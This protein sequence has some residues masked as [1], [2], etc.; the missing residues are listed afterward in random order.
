MTRFTPDQLRAILEFLEIGT[1]LNHEMAAAMKEQQD[2]LAT[3]VAA[4]LI[5]ARAF[6]RAMEANQPRIEAELAGSR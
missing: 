2:P 3:S 4:R 1:Y 5:Q 6:E